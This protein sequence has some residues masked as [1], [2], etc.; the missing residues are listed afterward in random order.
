VL[1]RVGEDL[2]ERADARQ[3]ARGSHR[4]ERI[5]ELEQRLDRRCDARHVEERV[6]A[7]ERRRGSALPRHEDAGDERCLAA[8]DREARGNRQTFLHGWAPRRKGSCAISDS[9]GR[10][11]DPDARDA[12]ARRRARARS[13]SLARRASHIAGDL[14]ARAR[15]VEKQ[16]EAQRIAVERPVF[17][18]KAGRRPL[19]AVPAAARARFP[20]GDRPRPMRTA[21]P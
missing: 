13:C 14:T 15:P 21:M 20:R 19:R 16:E 12:V 17:V 5:V 8:I 9:R 3:R 18:A 11:R 4:R 1:R 2:G 7:N 6:V 10:P